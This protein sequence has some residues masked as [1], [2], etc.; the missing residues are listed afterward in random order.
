[1]Q[2]MP[3]DQFT[4]TKREQDL[5]TVLLKAA[6]HISGTEKQQVCLRFAGGWVRDKV[7]NVSK[8]SFTNEDSY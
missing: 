7:E 4:L 6:Q 2:T 3:K 8:A 5:R 1:M